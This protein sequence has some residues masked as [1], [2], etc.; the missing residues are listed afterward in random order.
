MQKLCLLS[1]VLKDTPIAIS[2]AVI[3]S[4]S[5]E[6]FQRECRS[7]LE[8][9]KADGQFAVARRVAELAALPV[10]SLLIEQVY[11]KLLKLPTEPVGCSP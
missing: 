10:D 7:I 3:S 5:T 8:K 9:L 2:P 4:Y 1:Q 11:L 6:N